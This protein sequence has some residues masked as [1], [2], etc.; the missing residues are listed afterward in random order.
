MPAAVYM[1]GYIRVIK[2]HLLHMYGTCRLCTMCTQELP[3]EAQELSLENFQAWVQPSVNRSDKQ[4]A[5]LRRP[6]VFQSPVHILSK[7]NLTLNSDISCA[8]EA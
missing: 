4:T 6:P 2:Q 8:K 1:T 3:Q 7:Q 5:A